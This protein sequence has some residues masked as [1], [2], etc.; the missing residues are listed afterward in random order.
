MC[1]LLV[2]RADDDVE[3]GAAWKDGVKISPYVV[4][5]RVY[6][7]L[8]G[9]LTSLIFGSLIKWKK[10]HHLTW[11]TIQNAWIPGFTYLVGTSYF[12]D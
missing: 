8:G 5:T 4:T 10:Q 12:L 1:V 7:A 3:S 6:C 11:S 9:S 2:G